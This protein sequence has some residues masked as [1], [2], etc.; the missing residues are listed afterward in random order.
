M[1]KHDLLN[2]FMCDRLITW[3]LYLI[4]SFNHLEILLYEFPGHQLPK[5]VSLLILYY[6]RL[7]KWIL[8][9]GF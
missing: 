7:L 3:D 8:R 9:Q 6:L 4:D 5:K 2:Y 1:W